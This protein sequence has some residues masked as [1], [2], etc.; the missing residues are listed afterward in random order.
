MMIKKLILVVLVTVIAGL[1]VAYFARNALVRTAVE[2]GGTYAMGV[3]TSL[4]S[5]GLSL[6]A[7]S[8]EW[9]EDVGSNREGLEADHF[10]SIRRGHFDVNAG[11]LFDDE[12]VI[13]SLVLDGISLNIE[14]KGSDGNYAAIMDHIEQLEISSESESTARYRIGLISIR[15]VEVNASLDVLG[16]QYEQSL[17]VEDF[18]MRDVGGKSG[19]T[20]GEISA[21][22]AK[23]VVTRA[24]AAS[25]D[26]L[27][28]EY[29][30]YLK[31]ASERQLEAIKDDVVDEIEGVGKALFGS[32]KE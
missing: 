4:G 9:K 25:R 17:K 1:A 31:G 20:I 32:D 13:D 2:E 8:L 16:R 6:G 27:P 19:G 18:T 10:F 24:V 29:S 3:E 21:E 12:V 15:E 23:E 26:K 14:Q 7:G 11:S 5:A 28:D 22:I 30:R